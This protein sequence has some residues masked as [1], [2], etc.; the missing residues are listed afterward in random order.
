[1]LM[2]PPG[3]IDLMTYSTMSRHSTIVLHP[4]QHTKDV[5]HTFLS[6]FIKFGYCCFWGLGVGLIGGDEVGV[7]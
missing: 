5:L 3:R 6:I 1:M 2:G 4:T 7:F